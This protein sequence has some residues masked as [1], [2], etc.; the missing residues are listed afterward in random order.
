[1]KH[2]QLENVSQ[3]LKIVIGKLHLLKRFYRKCLL[4]IGAYCTDNR[5]KARTNREFN[6]LFVIVNSQ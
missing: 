4:Q 5:T 6:E 2:S 3:V 1:M